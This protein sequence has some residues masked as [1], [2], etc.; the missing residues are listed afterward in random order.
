MSGINRETNMGSSM[1]R[2]AKFAA[3][4]L[5]CILG[6]LHLYASGQT[7]TS[8]RIAGTI[9]DAQGAVII[10]AEIVVENR[11]TAEKR[12][13]L[14]DSTGNYSV[15]QLTPATYDVD[16]HASGFSPATYRHV[17]VGLSKTITI[18]A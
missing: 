15:L 7:Y 16:M 13:V 1:Q 10:G 4:S 8:G 18:N 2:C 3:L 6:V 11:A 14:T 12:L 5:P 17:T 9:R